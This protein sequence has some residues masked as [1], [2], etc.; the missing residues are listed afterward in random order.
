M[1][2]ERLCTIREAAPRMGLTE[3]KLRNMC[4]A[5]QVDHMEFPGETGQRVFYR[6][7]EEQIRAWLNAHTVRAVR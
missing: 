2:G 7:S 4:A 5:R 6:L 1:S 3:K